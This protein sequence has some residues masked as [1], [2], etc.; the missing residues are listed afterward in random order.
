MN[1]D[2]INNFND[3]EGNLL[4]IQLEKVD[5]ICIVV[6]LKGTIDTYNS[7]YFIKQIN[8]VINAGYSKLI[9]DLYD[10]NYMS[11]TG[12]GATVTILKDMKKINGAFSIIDMQPKVYEVFQLLGMTSFIDFKD[13][14]EEA[15][16]FYH[17]EI[18]KK[19]EP[20]K[21]KPIFPKTFKCLVCNRKL[22][23]KRPGRF[24]CSCQTIFT[25]NK[26]GKITYKRT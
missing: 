18:V 15:K 9:L 4:K 14:I 13:S 20:I 11:S 19:P 21:I 24:K 23:I 6:H 10:I 16:A 3:D 7:P 1:N 22:R 12:V 5:D 17:K 2:I 26:L 8:K 25:V